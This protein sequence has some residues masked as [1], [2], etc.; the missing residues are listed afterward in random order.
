MIRCDRR[1]LRLLIAGVMT[2]VAG[3]PCASGTD[4]LAAWNRLTTA[5]SA[6]ASDVLAAAH[7][8]AGCGP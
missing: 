3:K 2:L 5:A 4:A 8:T 1:V 7:P 6:N